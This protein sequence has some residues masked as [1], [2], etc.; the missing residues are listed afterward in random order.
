MHECLTYLK[1][2][3]IGKNYECRFLLSLT[4]WKKAKASLRVNKVRKQKRL[5][6]LRINKKA[7]FEFI[8]VRTILTNEN[9]DEN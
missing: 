5:F 3:I 7:A 8:L 9:R 6:A 2:Y 1:S 4:H